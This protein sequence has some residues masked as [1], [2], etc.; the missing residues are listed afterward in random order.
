MQL[1]IEEQTWKC[2]HFEVVSHSWGSSPCRVSGLRL[3]LRWTILHHLPQ[4]TTTTIERTQYHYLK[5][6]QNNTHRSETNM[7]MQMHVHSCNITILAYQLTL[8][9]DVNKPTLDILLDVFM[10][11]MANGDSSLRDLLCLRLAATEP[12]LVRRTPN[13]SWMSRLLLPESSRERHARCQQRQGWCAYI[14]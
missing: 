1:Q 2:S 3:S 4:P 5:Q 10:L 6:Q 13:I 11:K 12:V 8:H 14:N 9:A 7:Y